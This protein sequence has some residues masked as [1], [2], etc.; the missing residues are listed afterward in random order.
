MRKITLMTIL[1]S[2]L[3]FTAA[4]EA[5]AQTNIPPGS[6]QKS[7][8]N[9][10]VVGAELQAQCNEKGSWTDNLPGGGEKFSMATA[11]LTDFFLCADDISNDNGQF[12]CTK[13]N[14]SPLMK[15][16]EAALSATYPQVFG[17]PFKGNAVEYVRD[18]FVTNRKNIADSF[19]K[20]LTTPEAGQYWREYIRRPEN[21]QLRSAIIHRAFADVYGIDPNAT[22]VSPQDVAFWNAESNKGGNFYENIVAGET[23]KLNAPNNKIVRRSMIL[24]AY[25]KMMGR[26]PTKD[27]MAYWE[28]KT[29]NYKQIV[30]AGRDFLYSPNG[31]KD[32]AATVERALTEK[33]GSKPKVEQINAAM[34]QYAKTKAIFAEM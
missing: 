10:K 30:A 14:N 5:K 15:K 25:K 12:K 24:F 29:E 7:C 9:F 2:G 16:A 8:K 21:A 4:F 6:Y 13:N 18:M 26:V 20:G 3:F 27:D 33:S 34:L 32:L 19:F 23:K 17:K 11:P 22:P 31:A 1:L 28:P